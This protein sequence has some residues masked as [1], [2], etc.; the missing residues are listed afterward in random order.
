MWVGFTKTV[1]DGLVRG[2][3]MKQKIEG[4]KDAGLLTELWTRSIP[5]SCAVLDKS[6][7]R[8]L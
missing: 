5:S 3:V 2:A 7:T 1:V 8:S 4:H 6:K